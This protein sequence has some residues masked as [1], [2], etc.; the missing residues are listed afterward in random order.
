MTRLLFGCSLIETAEIET[1]LKA[2]EKAGV[3]AIVSAGWAGLGGDDIPD[4]VYI[5]DKPIPHDWLFP[6]VSAVCHHGGSGTTAMGLRMGKPTIVIPFSS[7]Q[8]WWG[9]RIASIGVGPEPI[10][11]K[12]LTVENL[13]A[14]IQ[15]TQTE[16]VRAAA[17]AVGQKLLEEVGGLHLIFQ[18]G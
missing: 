18:L 5:L 8:P 6:R 13:C 11:Y 1:I 12:N 4:S 7:D 17:E 15:F 3:R 2:V 9:R 14:A 10:Y 16:G